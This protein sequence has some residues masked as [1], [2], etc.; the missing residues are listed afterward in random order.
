MRKTNKSYRYGLEE[1]QG[2]AFMEN[3]GDDW[4]FPAARSGF[5]RFHDD[6]GN[7]HS[8]VLD[9]SDGFFYDISTRDAASGSGLSV[10]TKDKQLTDGSGGTNISGKIKTKEMRG[11]F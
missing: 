5:V 7:M 6:Q 3:T 9:Y 10:A 4:V 2:I 8:L 1:Q 11:T